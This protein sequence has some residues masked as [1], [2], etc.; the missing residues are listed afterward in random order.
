MTDHDMFAA[1]TQ[2]QIDALGASSVR[3]ALMSVS[4]QALPESILESAVRTAATSID[5]VGPLGDGSLALLSLKPFEEDGFAGFEHRFLMRLQHVLTP[6][7]R[8][9]DIGLVRFRSVHRWACELTDVYDLFN[10]LF[11]APSL[12]LPMPRI[13]ISPPVPAPMP[14][15][16]VTSESFP[17]PMSMAAQPLRGHRA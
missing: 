17:W 14:R 8:R 2:R 15:L 13:G 3:L 9:R 7:A 16:H 12:V 5:V 1:E 4:A 10:C 11:D 6:I